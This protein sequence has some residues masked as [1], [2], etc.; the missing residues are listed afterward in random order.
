MAAGYL[1]IELCPPEVVEE[2]LKN[3]RSVIPAE[4]RDPP[5]HP[6]GVV[7]GEFR[8]ADAESPHENQQNN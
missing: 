4:F 6:E 7:E 5:A 2:H 3:L 8:D 1:F